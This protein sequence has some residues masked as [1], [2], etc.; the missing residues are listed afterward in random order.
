MAKGSGSTRTSAGKG[1]TSFGGG[2]GTLS[3]NSFDNMKASQ[4]EGSSFVN[5]GSYTLS[6]KDG[7]YQMTVDTEHGYNDEYG[8]DGTS[9]TISMVKGTD[10]VGGEVISRG[11][12]EGTG[13]T[14]SN[15]T[16][17]YRTDTELK[18]TIDKLS[19]YLKERA[20]NFMR[21]N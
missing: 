1:N 8:A 12:I 10:Y 4:F 7:K 15:G 2:K 6:T 17:L 14:G 19:P 11:F 20:R 5:G 9:Y 16:T 3:G 18:N 21:N 13:V